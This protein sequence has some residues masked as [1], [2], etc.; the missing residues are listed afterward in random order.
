MH[1]RDLRPLLADPQAAWPHP[2]LLEN[3]YVQFGSQTD[4]GCTTGPTLNGIPWW[5]S[6]IDARHQYIRP[7]APDI[8]EK[9]YE[10]GKDRQELRNLAL[11]ADTT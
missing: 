10:Y 4:G 9:F 2:V 6:L 8:V 7:L 11:D 3:F 1:G 5:L